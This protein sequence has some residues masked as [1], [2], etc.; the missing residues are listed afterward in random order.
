MSQKL[1][2]G[3]KHSP[4]MANPLHCS[5]HKKKKKKRVLARDPRQESQNMQV[6]APSL[7]NEEI[8][9]PFRRCKGTDKF[10]Y[11]DQ[12]CQVFHSICR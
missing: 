4:V 1:K 2:Q 8:E 3:K 11:L 10:A 12:R 5:S 6:R 9:R 7:Q